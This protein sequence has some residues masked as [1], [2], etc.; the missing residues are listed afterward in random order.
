MLV[1]QIANPNLSL[2]VHSCVNTELH[3][4]FLTKWDH[5]GKVEWKIEC[6]AWEKNTGSC[7]LPFINSHKWEIHL[8]MEISKQPER[9]LMLWTKSLFFF[10]FFYENGFHF[11]WLHYPKGTISTGKCTTGA[12]LSFCH[13]QLAMLS[14]CPL[15]IP[16]VVMGFKKIS[17][18]S[19][20]P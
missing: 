15:S 1:A 3:I 11:L 2:A 8:K 7:N 10:L 17:H 16:D 20:S 5:L 6:V 14:E 12:L 18:F 13:H 9:N 4:T 19:Y